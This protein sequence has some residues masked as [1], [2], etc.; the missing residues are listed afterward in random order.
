[1]EFA[2]PV[3]RTFALTK[4]AANF[5]NEHESDIKKKIRVFRVDLRISFFLI[6]VY[7]RKSAAN[8]LWLI[9]NS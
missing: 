1:L 8:L 5:A 3:N 9:A 4:S 6:S 2:K 7:Q